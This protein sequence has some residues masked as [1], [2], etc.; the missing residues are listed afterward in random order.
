MPPM[1]LTYLAQL[2]PAARRVVEALRASGAIKTMTWHWSG[3]LW[4]Q[5]FPCYH[6]CAPFD[7]KTGR[8]RLVWTRSLMIPGE[9]TW[10][11]NTGNIGLS[12]MAMGRES[13]IPVVRPNPRLHAVQLQ[14]IEVIA[15]TTAEL[16]L[17]FDIALEDCH[18]HAHWATIDGYGPGSGNPETRVDVGTYEPVI[19]KK[20]AW[21][22]VELAAGRAKFEH[23]VNLR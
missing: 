1:I 7:E 12:L 2:S 21:Y 8:A 5:T 14:Q 22:M 10:H 6:G 4:H 23:T 19:R 13:R 15:K 17:L 11:R 9:H 3:G 20:A 16:C 18:D